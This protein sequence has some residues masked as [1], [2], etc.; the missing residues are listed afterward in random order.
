MGG[1]GCASSWHDLDLTFNLAKVTFNILSRPYLR[2][3]T[4]YEVDSWTGHLSYFIFLC[5]DSHLQNHSK[6]QFVL[7]ALCIILSA[8]PVY[9]VIC[10]H[11]HDINRYNDFFS[12]DIEPIAMFFV[13]LLF[14]KI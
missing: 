5:Q 1:C 13:E 11:L 7:A 10:T 6:I 9:I 12:S 4:V 14:F 3:C 8:C 2:N